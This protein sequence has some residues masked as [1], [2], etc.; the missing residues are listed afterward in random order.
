MTFKT[1]LDTWSSEIE[2]QRTEER[3]AVKLDVTDAARVRAL[4][5]LFPGVGEERVVTDLLSLAL[6]QL[7][8]AIPY[9]PGS[10]IIREDDYGDP[11]Y[12]DAGLT[13]RF[14]ELVKAHKT[15]LES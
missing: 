5:E 14:L 3:Y 2:P 8:A 10:E 6:D 15:E 1:L 9:E 4:A 12:A 7:E 11:I 13:P